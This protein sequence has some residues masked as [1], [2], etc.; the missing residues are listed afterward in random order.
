MLKA[1]HLLFWLIEILIN[2]GAFT[3]SDR[4]AL[5]DNWSYVFTFVATMAVSLP[6]VHWAGNRLEQK[7]HPA[8]VVSLLLGTVI[9][10]SWLNAEAGTNWRDSGMNLIWT[11]LVGL[12]ILLLLVLN[13]VKVKKD[14]LLVEKLRAETRDSDWEHKYL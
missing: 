4:L 6:L 11:I 10:V 13:P 2:H 9:L 5:N 3:L 1:K 14:P 8:L 12:F 7:L